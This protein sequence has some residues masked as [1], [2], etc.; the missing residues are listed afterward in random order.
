MCSSCR[1]KREISTRCA[2][3]RK[4][5]SWANAVKTGSVDDRAANS[6]EGVSPET[7]WSGDSKRYGGRYLRV[8]RRVLRSV[9]VHPRTPGSALCRVNSRDDSN[10][11]TVY[12]LIKLPFSGSAVADLLLKGEWPWPW[13]GPT[14]GG[15]F[16]LRPRR[17][18]YGGPQQV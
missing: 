17:G 9:Y 2:S 3:R 16:P 4:D 10:V 12:L 6:F 18:R 14:G 5:P 8:E 7:C 1:P 15:D 13:H 11:H